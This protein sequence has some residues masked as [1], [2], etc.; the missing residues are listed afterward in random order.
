MISA[1]LAV[2]FT[3]SATATGVEK[4]TPIEFV[5]AGA[6]TDRDYETLF[7]LDESIDS[8]C[9]RL[10]KAGVP[11]G[12][13]VDSAACRF[14]PIGCTLSLSPRI[15]TFLDGK[16]PEGLRPASLIYTGGTRLAD[17]SCAASTNMPAA[18]FSLY[19]L[20][21]APLIFNGV[22]PQ[23]DVY[24]CFT[25]KETIKKGTRVTFT[26]SCDSPSLPRHLDLTVKKGLLKEVVSQLHEAS[27]KGEVEAC[28]VMADD[29]TVREAIAVANAL[30]VIDS[31]KI[32]INGSSGLFY[33]AFLPL[34]KWRDRQERLTQPFELR[35]GN[36]DQLLFIEE[37]WT[38]DGPD[39]KLTPREI[40]FADVRLHPKT[41]T[42]FIYVSAE[43][44]L[45]EVSTAIS[46]FKGNTIRN[47]YVFT[48]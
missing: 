10:E 24:G 43:T 46:K 40:S 1:L 11:R 34:E 18:V 22:Y 19:S 12:R 21:Q 39:P 27:E 15:E 42:C 26:L 4:G 14:W 8:F 47:W 41:D 5:F 28:L 20:A 3:F 38:V 45:K 23:G 6:N 17:G 33:R 25:A 48:L 31:P 44:S 16:M 13:P 35:L 36:P 9:S 37:D 30:A 2:A 7:I 32:K 29:L